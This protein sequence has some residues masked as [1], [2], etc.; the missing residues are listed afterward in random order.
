MCR[1]T[2]M[3]LFCA[4]PCA[5]LL[6]LVIPLAAVPATAQAQSDAKACVANVA[7]YRFLRDLEDFSFLRDPA[8]RTDVFDGVKHL[9]FSEDGKRFVTLGGDLRLQLVNARYLSFGTEG[10]DN[11]DVTLERIHLHASMRFSPALRI[12][13]E[14]KS[15]DEQNREPAALAIDVNRLDLHQAFADFGTGETSQLRIGRQ[16]LVYGSGRRIFPRNGPNVRGSLDA[17]RWMTH[18]A[19]WRLDAFT[20]RPVEIDRGVFD[21]SKINTQAFWGLYGTGAVSAWTPLR[22]DVYYIGAHR[23]V[24][25]FSQGVAIEHRHSIGGRLFGTSGA[26]DFDHELT[27]QWGNFGQASIKAWSA[28]G[29][30]GYSWIGAQGRPR[31]SMRLAIGSGDRDPKEPGLQTFNAF[32]PRGGVVSEGFN[33]S[34]ANAMQARLALDVDLAPSL[35][36][37]TALETLSRTSLRDGIYGPGGNLLRA[38]GTSMARHVGDDIDASLVWKIDRHATLSFAFG[39]FRSGRF[40]HESGAPRDMRFATVTCFY[41]F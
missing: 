34:P 18:A 37:I 41:R 12:F 22:L 19:N 21:D 23:K 25:R 40:I 33:V 5:L 4:T 2:T 38:P 36:A 28:T 17:V 29:E 7:P 13:T 1:S 16:E 24:A 31:L 20:F 6:S 15:N 26:W 27:L 11:H 30:T 35:K 8:C 32:F 3:K 9:A 10:G 39:H 14:L